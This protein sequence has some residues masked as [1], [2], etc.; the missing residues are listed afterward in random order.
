[1]QLLLY[2]SQVA[3]AL[4]HFG[5][6]LVQGFV[7]GIALRIGGLHIIRSHTHTG[8]NGNGKV[9]GLGKIANSQP[10]LVVAGGGLIGG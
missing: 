9:L 2:L 4:A 1:M 3:H 7:Q 5:G 10:Y 8:I 6:S